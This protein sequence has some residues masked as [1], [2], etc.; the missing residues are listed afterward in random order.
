MY[1][2]RTLENDRISLKFRIFAF[3]RSLV[4]PWSTEYFKFLDI[5]N[6]HVLIFDFADCVSPFSIRPSIYGTKCRLSN[7]IYYCL[8]ANIGSWRCT[9]VTS[10]NDFRSQC[11]ILSTS[12][13]LI[14]GRKSQQ[15]IHVPSGKQQFVCLIFKD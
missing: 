12:E 15:G 9:L 4:P 13:R 1:E 10:K 7:R 2:C 5:F 3:W 8:F 6:I 11:I 14:I